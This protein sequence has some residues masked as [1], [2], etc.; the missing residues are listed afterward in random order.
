[1]PP[2]PINHIFSA[3]LTSPLPPPQTDCFNYVRF[4]QSYN[5]SHLYACGTY[6]FQPKCAYIVSAAPSPN[7]PPAP[8]DITH[9]V[10]APRRDIWRCPRAHLGV[11]LSLG[12]AF[13]GVPD[14]KSITWGW[15]CPLEDHL[16]GGFC[17]QE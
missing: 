7:P 12:M 1:M 11:S 10:P 2:P 9:S 15:S 17:A 14:P 8:R 4:L 3:P 6:A 16:W 5:S 13:G